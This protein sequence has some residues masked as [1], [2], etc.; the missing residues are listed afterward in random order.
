MSRL[1][2]VLGFAAAV[3]L[4][5]SLLAPS[6]FEAE[7]AKKA[8]NKQCVGTSLTGAKT[9]FKCKADEKCCYDAVTNTGTCVAASGIC[10]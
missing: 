1:F 4:S 10:L 6:G 9:T 8:K 7:A 5:V 3:T 2:A